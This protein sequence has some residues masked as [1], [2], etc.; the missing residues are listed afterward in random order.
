MPSVKDTRAVYSVA[1]GLETPIVGSWS[2]KKYNLVGVYDELFA[3]GMKNIWTRVYID[4]FA[5]PGKVSIEGTDR[6]LFGSPLLALNVPDRFDRYIFCEQSPSKLQAL[7]SRVEKE[8]PNVDAHFLGNCNEYVSDILR[9]IPTP[10]KTKKVLTFCFVD[11]YSL[12]PDFSTIDTLSKYYV[13]FLTLLALAMDGV[14]NEALYVEQNK[15][16][17]DRFLGDPS[18][19]PRWE[20]TSQVD[21]SFMRFLAKEYVSQ[22]IGLGYGKESLQTME[23]VRSDKNNLPLYHLAF[24][25]RNP[26]GYKFW[27]E[28]RKYHSDQATFDFR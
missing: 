3:T 2:E 8:Y 15:K 28:A 10:S 27:K 22:M 9:L 13:D 7:R 16:R 11:P 6:I 18:W 23:P 14:R 21:S 19:R 17:I 20:K 26:K 5:G 12:E 24:F 1:D 25:S 4:L